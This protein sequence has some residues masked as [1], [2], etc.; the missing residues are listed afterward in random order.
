MMLYFGPLTEPGHGFFDYKGQPLAFNS[1]NQPWG[2]KIDGGLNGGETMGKQGQAR[3]HHK[4]GWTAMSFWD[5]SVDTRPGCSSVY[6]KTGLHTFDE[7]VG[8][9]MKYFPERWAKMGFEVREVKA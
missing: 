7:M 2:T 1:V 6:L 9:A 8:L 5:S 3:I 4:D